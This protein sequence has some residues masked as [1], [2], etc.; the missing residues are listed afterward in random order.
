[1][2]FQS[3]SLPYHSCRLQGSVYPKILICAEVRI[4][5]RSILSVTST[6]F[7]EF[8]QEIKKNATMSPRIKHDYQG[9]L[10]YFVMLAMFAHEL[11][12]D[13]PA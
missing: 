13:L 3:R 2:R 5:L 12:T 10:I 4:Y 8:N 11:L 7:D 1:M 9:C 6:T